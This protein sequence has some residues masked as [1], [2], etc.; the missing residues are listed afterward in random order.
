MNL[1]RAMDRFLLNI[2]SKAKG[3]N[4]RF[5]LRICFAAREYPDLHY[6]LQNTALIE[7]HKY[8]KKDI[9]LYLKERL[10]STL[11]D[12]MIQALV[13]KAMGVFIWPRLV[14]Q[15]VLDRTIMS[16]D[17]PEA[18][19]SDIDEVPRELTALYRHILERAKQQN[20]PRLLRMMYWLCYA[21]R[22]LNICVTGL[23]G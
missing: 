1:I 6:C 9:E 13:S 5:K 11:R 21:I 19:W 15:E 16:H 3:E 8:N 18:I 14:A 17:S 10:G 22:P 20:K 4:L 12:W 23:R 7:V 2:S